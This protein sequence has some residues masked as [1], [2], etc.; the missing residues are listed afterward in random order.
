MRHWLS[1]LLVIH[2][3]IF[4]LHI[5]E[6]QRMIKMVSIWSWLSCL[7]YS[8]NRM[9]LMLNLSRIISSRISCCFHS[10]CGCGFLYVWWNMIIMTIYMHGCLVCSFGRFVCMMSCIG[11]WSRYNWRGVCRLR[12]CSCCCCWCRRYSR[13]CRCWLRWSSS[14]R[15]LSRICNRRN[16]RWLNRSCLYWI[17][18]NS[19]W[20]SSSLRRYRLSR[21]WSRRSRGYCCCISRLTWLSISNCWSLSTSRIRRR[22]IL[23]TS[24]LYLSFIIIF[25]GFLI[26]FIVFWL[27]FHLFV[28]FHFFLVLLGIFLFLLTFYFSMIFFFM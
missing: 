13:L 9:S 14:D 1:R 11:L 5:L 8:R 26:V 22:S 3:T 20:L 6:S 17:W 24:V 27:Y 15:R 25:I 19:C 7:L 21:S 12:W 2:F 4:T 28:L 23:D 16:S 18:L 10:E